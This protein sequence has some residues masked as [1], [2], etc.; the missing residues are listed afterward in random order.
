MLGADTRNSAIGLGWWDA[1]S[2]DGVNSVGP[3]GVSISVGKITKFC[4]AL[5]SYCRGKWDLVDDTIPYKMRIMSCVYVLRL[6]VLRSE[7]GLNSLHRS[8]INTIRMAILAN[9]CLNA[10][11]NINLS[12]PW[13]HFNI[14][15]SVN[16][17]LQTS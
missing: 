12:I 7:T 10:L 5:I 16:I 13:G 2:I 9:L 11:E 8:S 17:T 1:S 6:L 15:K 3:L 4:D 14:A